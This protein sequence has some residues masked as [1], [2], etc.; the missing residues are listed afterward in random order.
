MYRSVVYYVSLANLI[1]CK[2]V[3]SHGHTHTHTTCTLDSP[4]NGTVGPAAIHTYRLIT[5]LTGCPTANDDR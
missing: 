2:W 4:A 3:V 5:P 1:N